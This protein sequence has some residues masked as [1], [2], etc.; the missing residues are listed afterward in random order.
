MNAIAPLP[1]VEPITAWQCIGCGRLEAYANCVGVCQDR[2]IELVSGWDYAEAVT[3]L[4]AAIERI[5]A[6]ESLVAKLAN[7]T[8]R[9]DAYRAG[10]TPRILRGTSNR[11][12]SDSQPAP[13][14]KHGFPE[15]LPRHL[16]PGEATPFLHVR[17]IRIVEFRT[18]IAPL[19]TAPHPRTS[20]PAWP[21]ERT[22]SPM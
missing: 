11:I 22:P 10:I 14:P 3:R 13:G 16:S 4:E 7:T 21:V 8:P 2:R 20:S 17:Q 5:A 18:N 6:L 9:D 19:T 1:D 12:T 15:P